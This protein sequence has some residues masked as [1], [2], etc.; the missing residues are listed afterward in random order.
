[1]LLIGAGQKAESGDLER[2]ANACTE[3]WIPAS[4][5]MTLLPGSSSVMPVQAGIQGLHA[6]W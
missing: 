4:A 5:G 2:S 1:M 3:N 6:V